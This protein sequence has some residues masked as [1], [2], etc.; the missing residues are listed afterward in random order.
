MSVWLNG[1]S[2]ANVL[3]ILDDPAQGPSARMILISSSYSS[4]LH[5]S[6]FLS[7]S[8]HTFFLFPVIPLSPLLD[9]LHYYIYLDVR[10]L[11][12]HL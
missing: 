1:T 11:S 8:F 10:F 4:S 9:F 3:S 12:K 5:F 6:F 7:S 2:T